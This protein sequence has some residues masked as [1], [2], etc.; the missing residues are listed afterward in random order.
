MYS[1]MYIYMCYVYIYID[2]NENNSIIPIHI[3]FVFN[4][5]Q[6]WAQGFPFVPRLLPPLFQGLIDV[7]HSVF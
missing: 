7:W 6:P 2:H 1:C 3:Q 5:S 4:S